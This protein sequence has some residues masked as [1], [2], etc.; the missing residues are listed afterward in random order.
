[1]LRIFSFAPSIPCHVQHTYLFSI[2]ASTR[3]GVGICQFSIV[4]NE[5]CG[6]RNEVFSQ[7][8]VY[9]NKTRHT[10]KKNST[11]IYNFVMQNHVINSILIAQILCYAVRDVSKG[12]RHIS[13]TYT[14][15]RKNDLQNNFIPWGN[16]DLKFMFCEPTAYYMSEY[17]NKIAKLYFLKKKSPR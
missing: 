5:Q 2:C 13:N 12:P 17:Q 11:N 3:P 14:L 7:K 15:T 4:Y 10:V 1:M 9:A 6:I 8:L 16:N